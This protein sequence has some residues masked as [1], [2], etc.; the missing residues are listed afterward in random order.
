MLLIEWFYIL[1]HDQTIYVRK[2]SAFEISY[3]EFARVISFGLRSKEFPKVWVENHKNSCSWRNWKALQP[4]QT[5]EHVSNWHLAFLEDF[6][7]DKPLNPYGWNTFLKIF[8]DCESEFLNN[9]YLNHSLI[10]LSSSPCHRLVRF[11]S[12]VAHIQAVYLL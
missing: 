9:F 11:S 5:D 4:I 12:C 10:S 2:I 7:S 1:P 3:I 6:K 8:L